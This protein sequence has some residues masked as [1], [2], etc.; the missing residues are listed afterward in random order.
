MDWHYRQAGKDPLCRNIPVPGCFHWKQ[1]VSPAEPIGGNG[2]RQLISRFLICPAV[3]RAADKTRPAKCAQVGTICCVRMGHCHPLPPHLGRCFVTGLSRETAMRTGDTISYLL[4]D[5]AVGHSA[6][7]INF[8]PWIHG[9]ACIT[10]RIGLAWPGFS[11]FQPVIAKYRGTDGTKGT[12]RYVPRC[13]TRSIM[14]HI[15]ALA[16]LSH[17]AE[18]LD[19]HCV[20]ITR[21]RRVEGATTRK[22]AHPWRST[23]KNVGDPG[24]GG[25]AET[26]PQMATVKR[27]NVPLWRRIVSASSKGLC[28]VVHG[29]HSRPCD[30]RAINLLR[31]QRAGR[32]QRMV[33]HD[34]EY[35]GFKRSAFIAVSTQGFS[36]FLTDEDD[37]G[38]CS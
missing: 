31:Q 30:H 28:R 7:R 35:S 5:H 9:P 11:A 22:P 20:S 2:G 16:G 1:R 29:R 15:C 18:N 23:A 12:R 19:T 10:Q 6:R 8:Q 38:Q 13:Q 3:G 33:A 36:P 25:C 34:Q 24:E 37:T 26:S 21:R 14:T 4:A 17:I 27:A 32:R